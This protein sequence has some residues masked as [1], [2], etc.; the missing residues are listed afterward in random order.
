MRP[1]S[2]RYE[3]SLTNSGET[4]HFY[5]EDMA[6][7]TQLVGAGDYIQISH[8][9]SIPRVL[10]KRFVEIIKD[11]E[12]SLEF[13]KDMEDEPPYNAYTVGMSYTYN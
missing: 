7:F 3:Y 5:G 8:K 13:I 4:L 1:K 6:E 9:W 12:L 11:S 2:L 10:A